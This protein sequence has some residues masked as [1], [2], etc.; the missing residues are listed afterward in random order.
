MAPRKMRSDRT[1]EHDP[2]S[3]RPL[4]S[5]Q[6]G[7]KCRIEA[8]SRRITAQGKLSSP[9]TSKMH[10]DAVPFLVC[11]TVPFTYCHLVCYP[12]ISANKYC[13]LLKCLKNLYCFRLYGL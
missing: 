1:L 12:A 4:L 8:L 3:R 7:T 2:T 6:G 11:A 13:C 10:V 5:C 9:L